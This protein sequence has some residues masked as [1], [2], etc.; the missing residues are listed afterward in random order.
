MKYLVEVEFSTDS[1]KQGDWIRVYSRESASIIFR[2]FVAAEH[3]QRVMLTDTE[4]DEVLGS[5]V[6]A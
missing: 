3:V 6:A 4:S 2:A 1:A 5:W